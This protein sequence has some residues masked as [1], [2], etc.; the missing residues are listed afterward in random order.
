MLDHFV[1]LEID[2]IHLSNPKKEPMADLGYDVEN[3]YD[4]DPIFGTMEDFEE[5]IMELKR[6]GQ[7]QLFEHKYPLSVILI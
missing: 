2:T 1:D 7:Q 6:N 4:I 5:L 3:F